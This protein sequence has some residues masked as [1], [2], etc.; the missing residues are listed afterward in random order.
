V[1]KRE[2]AFWTDAITDHP[3]RKNIAIERAPIERDKIIN[4][5]Q[6]PAKIGQLRRLIWLLTEKKLMNVDI[7]T[8]GD[9]KGADEK[10]QRRSCGTDPATTLPGICLAPPA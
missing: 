3:I 5:V 2:N 9:S 7:T 1:R 10:G 6:Q 8:I 4:V